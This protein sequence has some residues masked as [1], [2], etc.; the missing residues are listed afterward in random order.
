[1]SKGLFIKALCIRYIIAIVFVRQLPHSAITKKSPPDFRRAFSLVLSEL[2]VE[3]GS[4]THAIEQANGLTLR[5]TMEA[6]SL[7][8]GA[9][10]MLRYAPRTL[11]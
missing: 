5:H 1:M 11:P 2:A 3:N 4:N 7:V 9:P 8:T 10:S 6:N